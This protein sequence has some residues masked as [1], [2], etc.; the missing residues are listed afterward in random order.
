MKHRGGR[1]RY[2]SKKA[3]RAIHLCADVAPVWERTSGKSTCGSARQR[4]VK[5]RS[6]VHSGLRP[7][8][9]AV[10]VNDALDGG[11]PDARTR[12]LGF[13]VQA[14]ERA[15]KLRSVAGIEART[16]VAHEVDGAAGPVR[17]KS[18]IDLSACLACG[19]LPCVR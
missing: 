10:A 19:E 14:L 13:R 9:A 8:F 6:T 12:E 1:G 11:Q 5:R 17:S 4:E 16:V 18:E 2:L 7:D 3:N 15:E